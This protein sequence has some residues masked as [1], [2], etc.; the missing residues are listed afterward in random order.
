MN[1]PSDIDKFEEPSGGRYEWA[2]NAIDVLSSMR[3]FQDIVNKQNSKDELY[4]TARVLISQLVPMSIIAFMEINDNDMSFMLAN[5][6]P[7]ERIDFIQTAIDEQIE[8]GTFA[9]AVQQNKITTIPLAEKDKTLVLHVLV[10]P[11]GVK[12]MFAGLLDYNV[13]NVHGI[14]LDTVSIV[15]QNL[16]SSLDS[17]FSKQLINNYNQQLEVTIKYRTR[18]LEEAKKLAE[19]A[20]LAKSD[21]LASMS[22]ELNT[23]FNIIFGYLDLILE[24]MEFLK[25]DDSRLA[26]KDDLL[27]ISQATHGL[28]KMVTNI[29]YLAKL[30][31]GRI[32]VTKI[33]FLLNEMMLKLQQ[34]FSKEV[35]KN[36]NIL[37][38]NF[39]SEKITIHSDQQLLE[40]AVAHLLNNACKF[41]ENGEVEIL[42]IDRKIDVE[43]YVVISVID[44]GIGLDSENLEKVFSVFTQLD[45]SD[46]K[47]FEGLGLGLSITQ[48]LC[49][50]I[51]AKLEVESELGKGAKFSI[52]IPV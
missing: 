23:P 52:V 13:D 42:V 44:S 30:E 34:S 35:D 14:G 49:G 27:K 40:I 29:I 47:R 1:N 39:E 5:C 21:F 50:L 7:E 9:W 36:N 4:R 51:D 22:H 6:Y 45:G 18:E 16:A 12:G 3:T 48:R 32:N 15:V 8:K 31:A 38:L 2:L 24:D 33:D 10:S 19:A 11:L 46:Q 41:T 17:Y 37:R 20:N 26:L 28:N 25:E 43:E